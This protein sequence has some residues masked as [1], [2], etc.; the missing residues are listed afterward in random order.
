MGQEKVIQDT[1]GQEMYN[2]IVPIYYRDAYGAIVVFEIGSIQSFQKVFF[3]LNKV[4]KWI[5]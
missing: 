1:A 4:K 2:A 5:A 3:A